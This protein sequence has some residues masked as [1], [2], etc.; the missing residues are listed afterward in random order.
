MATNKDSGMIQESP[1]KYEIQSGKK[2]TPS[3]F[4]T[5]L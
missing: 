5:L 3:F 2:Q 4:Q 1:E